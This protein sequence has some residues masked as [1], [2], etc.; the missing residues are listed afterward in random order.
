V[1]TS[2]ESNQGE[3]APVRGPTRAQQVRAVRSAARAAAATPGVAAPRQAVLN[4]RTVQANGL[5]WVDIQRPG[6][7]EIE[8]LRKHYGFHPLHLE[9]VISKIQRPKLDE[10]DDYIFLVLHWPVY[11]KITRLTTASEVD[12]FIGKDY[13]IT[14]HAGHLR[15][16]LRYFQQCVDDEEIRNRAMR[17]SSGYLLYRI[18]D[19][20]I[21]YC[22][23][24]LNKIDQNIE[25]I[26]DMIFAD[27]VRQTVYEISLIRRD[28]IAFRRVI[29]PQIG[30]V[31]SLERRESALA[32]LLGE[33]LGEYFSDLSDH[34]A[35]IWDTLEDD[36]DVIEGLSDT[37]N[38]LTNTR[39]ND[40]IKVLTILSVVLLPLTLLSSIYGMNFDNLPLS[41][42][43]AVFW[44][45]LV[46]MGIIAAAMLAYFKFRRWI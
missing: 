30:V 2:T 6:R 3:E 23:A 36:K 35:K 11:N 24:P 13:L 45:A 40:V 26:E 10:R 32:P 42:H 4:I 46:A 34:M 22:F 15:P 8:W 33:D 43:P 39:I 7:A 44:I 25:T 14:I 27:N 20:L 17:R 16:L 37:N 12:I 21:D 41:T 9:D 5:T 28:I 31:A 38:S 29:K 18:L 19:K 1:Q